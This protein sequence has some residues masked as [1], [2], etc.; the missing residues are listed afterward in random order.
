MVFGFWDVSMT[1]TTQYF[2][3]WRHQD[4]LINPKIK[5]NHVGRYVSWES[6]N[7]GTPKK[8]E[9]PSDNFLEI[10]NMESISSNKHEMETLENLE[11]G[12]NIFQNK[13]EM[14]IL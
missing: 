6:Q 13:H 7:R 2:A 11:Y 12:I 1:P 9:D 10:L 4:T 8:P 14:A 3:L 5:Q